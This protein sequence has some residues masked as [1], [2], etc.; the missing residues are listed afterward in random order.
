[1]LFRSGLAPNPVVELMTIPKPPSRLGRVHPSPNPTAVGLDSIAFGIP[2]SVPFATRFGKE[3]HRLQIFCLQPPLGIH[4]HKPVFHLKRLWWR[5]NN[6]ALTVT[7]LHMKQKPGLTLK[8]V[9]FTHLPEYDYKC[10]FMRLV[11]KF[12]GWRHGCMSTY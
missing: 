10:D 12:A 4:P 5:T 2:H 9:K 6:T 1:M 8:M 11:V 7:V 3:G